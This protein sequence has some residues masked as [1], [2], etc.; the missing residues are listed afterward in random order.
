MGPISHIG[1]MGVCLGLIHFHLDSPTQ[2]AISPFLARMSLG[3]GVMKR[4]WCKWLR[5]GAFVLM[6]ILGCVSPNPRDH[7]REQHKEQF[8]V[9][10][11]NDPRFDRPPDL[12]EYLNKRNTK[13]PFAK[14]DMPQLG[15][16]GGNGPGM[17]GAGMASPGMGAPGAGGAPH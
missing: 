13:N 3:A 17:T 2:Q 16:P 10:P 4:H 14:D 12:S 6:G 15:G 1:P 9:P 11:E 5:L 8:N 7:L